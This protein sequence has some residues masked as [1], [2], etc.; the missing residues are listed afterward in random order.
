MPGREA[1]E[2]ARSLD[3]EEFP[4]WLDPMLATATDEGPPGGDWLFERKLDGVRALAFRGGG[5]VRLLSRA[6]KPIEAPYPE[7][8]A[9]LAVLR[10]PDVV[11]DGEIVAFEDGR[12][13][14]ER[15]Q[16]RMQ[17]RDPA[18]ARAT[19]VAI[20]YHVFDLLHVDGYS[21]R[22]LPLHARKALL[23][24]VV[25]FA[26]PLRFTTHRT[27]DGDARLREACAAGWEGLIAKRAASTYQ[28][29]RSRDW[30]KLKCVA[31][32]DVVIGGYTDPRGGR[33][34]FGALLVGCHE[35]GELR[36][37]G[38]VGTGFDEATLHELGARLRRLERAS[39][40]FVDDVREPAAHW[41]A[42]ELV[43][44]VGFSD[45][46]DAGRLRHPRFLGLREDVAPSEVVREDTAE[47]R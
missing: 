37:A 33:T 13:S 41:V 42:P 31:E 14:F 4:V 26:E 3:P 39:S 34:A 44:R 10:G 17:K 15:L 47:N 35:G 29:R 16:R 19:G 11:L 12:T 20:H 23:A 28:H 8:V 36:Y 24:E 9:A 40:P 38:K 43:A 7:V 5:T 1:A 18:A 22:R 30:L 6:R 27:G 32:Q 21:T 2:L 46:T 25:S 45:W